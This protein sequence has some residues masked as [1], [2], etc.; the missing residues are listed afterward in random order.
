MDSDDQ[1]QNEGR[2]SPKAFLRSRRPELFSDSLIEQSK[3]LDRS[4]LEYHLDTLTKRSQETDFEHFARKLAEHEICPNLIPHTGPTGGGDSKVDT[5]TFP[6]ADSLAH[7]WYIGTGREAAQERWAFA[8]SA[9]ED[10]QAKVKSDIKKIA[11]T[12]RGYKKAY[13]ISSRYIPDK[14]RA[15]VEDELRKKHKLDVRILDL[16]WILDRVFQGRYENLAI[17]EL[18]LSPSLRTN[19][20]QGSQDIETERVLTEVET[21]ITQATREEYFGHQFVTDCIKACKLSRALERPR[22]E[23]DG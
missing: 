22:T 17:E 11:E 8:I 5:E 19:V 18:R 4:I 16:S 9:K 21:R 7:A 15:R 12:K 3:G 20:R 10:W 1:S 6:V 23:T 14:L 13:F 2:F